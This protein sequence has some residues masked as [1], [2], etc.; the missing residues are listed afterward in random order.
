MNKLNA[1][2]FYIAGAFRN[3]PL[4]QQIAGQLNDAGATQTFDWT[5]AQPNADLAT[6][7]DIAQMEQRGITSC[8]F[9]VFVFPGGK[10]ANIEFGIATALQKPIFIFD[11]TDT[12]NNIAE[13]TTFYQMD[14][15]QKYRGTVGGFVN[16]IA[17]NMLL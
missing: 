13:T 8:D 16:F 2:H 15:V 4:V 10:G 7:K 6:L 5:Q 9:L 17:N 3:V 12:V 11:T 14:H 1:Q